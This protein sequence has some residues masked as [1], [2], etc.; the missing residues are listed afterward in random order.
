MRFPVLPSANLQLLEI[1]AVRG[2]SKH[3]K[4][5]MLSITI[6][7]LAVLP[8]I[9][10]RIFYLLALAHVHL[11]PFRILAIPNI[12]LRPHIHLHGLVVGLLEK[13]ARPDYVYLP[14]ILSYFFHNFNT[15]LY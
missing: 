4:D 15:A 3:C 11:W 1:E 12:A 13:L 10:L 7:D 8:D 14:P 2:S 9:N 6:R 5:R